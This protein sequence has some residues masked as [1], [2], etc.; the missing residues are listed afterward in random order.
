[1]NDVC[2]ALYVLFRLQIVCW[3]RW[4]QQVIYMMTYFYIK[5]YYYN[6]PEGFC[7]F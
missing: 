7:L 5:I 3:L 1:M 4:P 2:S 6:E